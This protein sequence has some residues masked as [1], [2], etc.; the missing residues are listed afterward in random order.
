MYT[1]DSDL[2]SDLHKEAYGFR[3]SSDFYNSW[4][5]FTDEQKQEEWNF[6]LKAADDRFEEDKRRE[7]EDVA[8]FD[9]EVAEIMK[10]GRN[11]SEYDAIAWMAPIE[12]EEN[13]ELN[14]QDIEHWVWSRGILFTDR[15][16]EVVEILKKIYLK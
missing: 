14:S 10:V 15:G 6:L 3:P 7:Q 13:P 2:I 9:R 4:K 5:E 8:E 16:R 12:F 11:C 1:F